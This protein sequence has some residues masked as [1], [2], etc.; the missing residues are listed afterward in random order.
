MNKVHNWLLV[1][2]LTVN[3]GK[4]EYMIIGTRQRLSCNSDDP[5]IQIGG[6]DL[7]R[8]SVTKSLGILVDENLNWNQ[9]IDNISKKVSKG[10]G[11]LRRVKQY[12]SRQSL[13]T[14]YQSLILPHFDYRSMVSGNCNQSLKKSCKNSKTELQE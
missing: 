11:I 13:Q 7:K 10:I 8:V 6:I 9:Q 2:K 4:T 5:K 12:I 3:V 14:I 1:N